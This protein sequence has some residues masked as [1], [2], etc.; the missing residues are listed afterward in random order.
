MMYELLIQRR[1]LRLFTLLCVWILALLCQALGSLARA[2]TLEPEPDNPSAGIPLILIHGWTDDRSKWDEPLRLMRESHG[3]WLRRFRIYRYDYDSL[4]AIEEN[5]VGLEQE[6]KA[7]LRRDE[8][9]CIVA[10]SMGGLVARSAIENYTGTTPGLH[11]RLLKLLTL[12]TPHHSSP[13]ANPA[14]LQNDSK[15]KRADTGFFLSQHVFA[16]ALNTPG[17]YGLGWDNSD[18]QMPRAVW[19]GQWGNQQHSP[20]LTLH[21]TVECAWAPFHQR[22]TFSICQICRSRFLSLR[23]SRHERLQCS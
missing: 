9:F 17:G 10:H 16:K 3:D 6:I 4:R 20:R 7:K 1:Q 11:R 15:M 12:A 23:R 2:G 19:E 8:P 13:F 5:G 22:R 18:R 14:W 21:A